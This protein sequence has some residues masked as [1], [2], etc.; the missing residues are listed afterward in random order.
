MES[1][2]YEEEQTPLHYAA[3]KGN[4]QAVEIL[5]E[6]FKADKEAKDYQGRTP[7]YLAAEYGNKK[8]LKTLLDMGCKEDVTNFKGQ[9]ALFWIIA[10][11]PELVRYFLEKFK[12]F[13]IFGASPPFYV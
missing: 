13:S 4:N 6:K 3:K 11:C 7:L 5:V 9:K 2:T 12:K 10:K 8:V 1:K